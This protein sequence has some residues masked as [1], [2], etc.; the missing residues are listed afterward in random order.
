[1]P[2]FVEQTGAANP[3]MATEG[4]VSSKEETRQLDRLTSEV[5]NQSPRDIHG[6]KWFLVI[7][8]ILST[9]LLYS[10]DNTIVADLQPSIVESY[11][12]T[13]ISKLSWLGVSYALGNV[14]TILPWCKAYGTFNI[15]WLYISHVLTFCVGSAICGA[16]PTLNV[17]IVGRAICGIGGC[18]LYAGCLTYISVTTTIQ[19]RPMYMGLVGLIWGAG[20]VLGPVVG[21]AFAESTATW[22]WAFYLNIVVGGTFSPVFVWMLPSIT[23][24]TNQ[25]LKNRLLRQ[26]D[27]LGIILLAGTSSCLTMA[28]TFGGTQYAWNSGSEITLWI[29]GAVILIAFCAS[30]VYHPFV[31]EKSKLYPTWLIRRPVHSILQILSF[32]GFVC[33]FVPTYYIP[34]YFQ[35]TRG[36]SPLEAGVRLLPFIILGVTATFLNGALLP[37][38]GYYMPWYFFG[39]TL[40][41]IGSA[42][43]YTTSFTTSVA[44]IY[45]YTILIGVGVGAFA[46]QSF[47]VSQ[48]LVS[49]E[50]IPDVVGFQSFGQSTAIVFALAIDGTIFQNEAIKKLS[51]LLPNLNRATIQGMV[52]GTDSAYYD[53]LDAVNREK[54]AAVIVD[55]I[56]QAYIIVIA[57]GALTLI[58]SVFLPR[59]KLF[60][61]GS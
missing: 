25:S 43:M 10:L 18:A 48:A 4:K 54:V 27:W 55:A 36:D 49:A 59:T 29:V 8:A 38:L 53:S 40:V 44:A 31:A 34:L 22:R 30:Q 24:S 35:F 20:T 26:T 45:G 51:K 32:C 52:A 57:A 2:D 50:E 17:L 37:V 61:K 14:A 3:A 1:M 33:L 23:L 13:E 9:T 19:E 12:S 42:L 46:Q 39:G 7:S 6:W 28:I 15:K 11:G 41:I 16:A 21:G 60:V 5:G 56:S 47:A 58:L